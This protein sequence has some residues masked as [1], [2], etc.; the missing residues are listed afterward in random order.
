MS[1]KPHTSI[2]SYYLYEYTFTHKRRAI[3]THSCPC[4]CV[5]ERRR[6]LVTGN[7]VKKSMVNFLYGC[8]RLYFLV[9]FNKVNH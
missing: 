4:V 8:I 9:S 2:M 7:A 6:I 3:Y 1:I 5:Y